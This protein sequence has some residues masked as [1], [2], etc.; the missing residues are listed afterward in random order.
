L[1]LRQRG[2]VEEYPERNTV[3]AANSTIFF[4]ISTEKE[5]SE[6]EGGGELQQEEITQRIE[7]W[8]RLSS[9]KG[10]GGVMKKL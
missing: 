10:N 3:R 9:L 6:K 4:D 5:V 7:D 1:K 8:P 2:E